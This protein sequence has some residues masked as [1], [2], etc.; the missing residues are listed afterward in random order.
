LIKQDQIRLGKEILTNFDRHQL[1]IN[2]AGLTEEMLKITTGIKVRPLSLA[3]EK[4]K[5]TVELY[6]ETA[7]TARDFWRDIRKTHPGSKCYD[8]PSYEQFH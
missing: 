1:Y 4:A 6:G 3:E 2:Q 7:Q 8:H 5:L